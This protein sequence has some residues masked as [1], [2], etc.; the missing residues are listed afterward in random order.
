MNKKAFTLAE[1]IGV[2]TLLGLIS[3][4][5]APTI[6]NQIGRAHV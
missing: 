6:I 4:L 1:L 5:I 2:I 3:V